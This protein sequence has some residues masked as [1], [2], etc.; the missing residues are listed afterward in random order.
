LD[1]DA[2][3]SN[4]RSKAGL[5]ESATS[6]GSN[7]AGYNNSYKSQGSNG[8]G[9]GSRKNSMTDDEREAAGVAKLKSILGGGGGGSKLKGLTKEVIVAKRLSENSR[10]RLGASEIDGGE[11]SLDDPD[12]VAPAS[13]LELWKAVEDGVC[14]ESGELC[15]LKFAMTLTRA[16]SSLYYR[17]HCLQGYIHCSGDWKEVSRHIKRRKGVH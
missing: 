4:T 10:I 17:R 12:L 1:V 15:V 6:L 13:V 2:I 16:H 11:A 14:D 9:A 3:I 8:S 5:S 7:G